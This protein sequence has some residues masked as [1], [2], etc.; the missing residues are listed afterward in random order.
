MP[1]LRDDAERQKAAREA[2]HPREENGLA[3]DALAPSSPHGAHQELHQRVGG[4]QRADLKFRQPELAPERREDREQDGQPEDAVEERDEE[5]GHE[6][7]GSIGT[8]GAGSALAHCPLPKPGLGTISPVAYQKGIPMKLRAMALAVFV[9]PVACGG[10]TGARRCAC[11][12]P[13]FGA[14][15]TR[16]GSRAS[17]RPPPRRRLPP[18]AALHPPPRPERAAATTNAEDAPPTA[19]DWARAEASAAQENARFTAELHAQSKA[20]ADASYP[21]TKAGLDA[22]LKSPHRKPG[23]Q[24]RD[25]YRHPVE[26]LEFLGLTP[27]MTVLEYGPGE[28]WV[29]E[30]LAPVLAKKGKLLVTTTDPNGPKTDRGALGGHRE[31]LMLDK[32]PEL[33]GKV[34]RVVIDP[35][36][37]SLPEDGTVDM[38]LLFRSMHGM[39]RAGQLP[40]WLA[41]IHKAL[42]PNGVLGVE[43]HRAA[44]ATNPDDGAKQGY[45][46][47]EWLI[48]QVEQAGFKLAGKSE[49]NANPKDMKDYPEG[50]WTLPPTYR[51]KDKDHD[52]YAAIGESDRMTLKFVKVGK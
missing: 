5:N 32:S 35:K 21:S 28:G 49:V 37:P 33:F 25:K 27:K 8:C 7:G 20:L 14:G 50:V 2:Q 43:Q 10:S 30:L 47:E 12:G 11:T 29:T 45:L 42:K 44:P 40:A 51:L 23:N 26:T 41:A 6:G 9:L 18:A 4:R 13:L 16:A 24:D 34:E 1:E 48:H 15:G 36:A 22:A 39:Q 31:A 46:P 52:K 19:D 17:D 38:A 3:S